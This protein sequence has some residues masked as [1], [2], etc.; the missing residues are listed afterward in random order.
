MKFGFNSLAAVAV[1]WIFISGCATY[2][3]QQVGPTAIL[4]AEEEIPEDQLMDVGVL[5]FKSR[6]IT[7]EE[8]EKEGTDN[9]IRKAENHFIPYHLKNTLQQSGQWGA[10]QV[11][12]AETN[13]IDVL[14]KGEILESN[15]QYLGLKIEVVDATGKRWFVKNYRQEAAKSDYGGNRPGE[16]DA[17]QNLY[18]AIAND[19]AD[20]KNRLSSEEIRSLRT[21]AKLKFAEDFAPDAFKGYLAQDKKDLV[22]IK[23]LPA[24][25]DPMMH[26][27]FRIREREYMYVDTLNQQYEKFYN[28]MWPSYEN[29]RQLNMTERKAIKEI[30]KRALTRQLIGALMIAGAVAAGSSDSNNTVVLQTGLILIGGQVILDGFNISKEAEI[31]EA[32]IR[33]LSDSFSG[34]MKPVVMEFE[35][36]QYELTGSAEE[37]FKKWRELLRKIYFAETGFEPDQIPDNGESGPAED[38]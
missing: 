15:G 5:V 34:E 18:N 20:F 26:R 37:Q 27:L 23:R 19:M 28:A 31:H 3:A 33:E 7:E 38:P 16:K 6:G 14:V 29:W 35:G 17:F 8:A 22:T 24:D 4:L 2:Y 9:D 13:S 1:I 30:R 11:V 21:T 10:V 12:P 32:A 25:D 36:K